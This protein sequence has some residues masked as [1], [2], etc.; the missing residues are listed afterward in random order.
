MNRYA[1]ILLVEDN[2][3]DELLILRAFKANKISNDVIVVRDGQEAVDWLR[4]EGAY[5]GRD[6]SV[7]PHL[8]LLDLKL[9][10][11]SGLEV[12]AIIR[13]DWH[14]HRLP[15]VILT[16]SDEERDV[17]QGYELRANSYIHKPVDFDQFVV[18]VTQ[19]GLYWLVLNNTP[20]FSPAAVGEEAETP[21]SA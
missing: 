10:K 1:P 20:S 8:V 9:P 21:A 13:S 4:G 12:L 11:L 15:V 7:L 6:L 16:S 3:D 14:T 18:A 17:L 2:P 19:L 5:D